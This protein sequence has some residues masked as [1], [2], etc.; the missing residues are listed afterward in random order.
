M[1]G[2]DWRKCSSETFV[3]YLTNYPLG[4]PVRHGDS[5]ALYYGAG[6]WLVAGAV[7]VFVRRGVVPVMAS[8]IPE[9][10]KNVAEK[11]SGFIHPNVKAGV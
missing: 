6:H 11:D 10:Q 1:T 8:G 9:I 3:L 7:G 2:G 4:R 5:I